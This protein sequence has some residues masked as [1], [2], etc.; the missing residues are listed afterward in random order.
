MNG[1]SEI[2][3]TLHYI[4]DATIDTG[5]VIGFSKLEVDKSKSLFWHIM[6]LYPASLEI[7]TSTIDKILRGNK[8]ET[9]IQTSDN[10]QYFTFPT[11]EEVAQFKQLGWSFMAVEEYES[12]LKKY[13]FKR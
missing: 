10:A 2:G 9:H 1:D 12:I 5:G 8:I 6:N 13:E 11:H 7:L 3:C 4:D